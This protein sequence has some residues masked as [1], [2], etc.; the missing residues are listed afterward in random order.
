MTDQA[1]PVLKKPPGYRDPAAPVQA[2]PKPPARKPP[3][4]ILPI[5]L[6]PRK[7]RRRYCRSICCYICLLIIIV[8]LLAAVAACCFYLYYEPRLPVFRL[9]S[10][11]FPLFNVT[12][13]QDGPEV[14]SRAVVR[15]EVKNPNNF[16]HVNYGRI[17][18]DLSAENVDL[19]TA[20]L[21]GFTQGKKN[22]TVV[23]LTTEVKGVLVG[24]EAE[25]K[26]LKEGV[27]SKGVVVG[28]EVRVGIGMGA[29]GWNTARASVTAVCGGASLKEVAY[30]FLIVNKKCELVVCAK[31]KGQPVEISAFLPMAS[32]RIL[33]E[34]K[35]LQKDPPTSCSAG[36]DG[37]TSHKGGATAGPVAE[38]MFHWQATIMG[39]ADSPYAGGVFLVTIHFP[40]DYPFKPPKVAF[41]TKVF[42]PNINS[43]GSICLDILKEQWSPALTISKVLLS[44]CSLL[45]DPNPDDPLVPEIAHMY[46]TDKG[47][48]EA[49]ARS[50]TQ[51]YA[52]G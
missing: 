23:K 3:Q 31:V 2:P 25:A 22:T 32:K 50:W 16:L 45:T 20:R 51:K 12:S 9:Q 41:R 18:A 35:D 40:P 6:R 43:N 33:K 46:K 34:L 27:R 4:P 36:D 44:I 29:N 5:S 38:D 52:M 28:A 19:G 1:K 37:K 17:E 15:I 26:R 24:N 42:H 11:Q 39:P 21:A 30:L 47:K 49:T 7:K 48:Y 13:G 14:N 10:L 8:T